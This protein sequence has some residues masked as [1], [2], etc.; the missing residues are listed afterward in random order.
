MAFLWNR[1]IG[2]FPCKQWSWRVVILGSLM[3]ALVEDLP[4]QLWLAFVG[5]MLE[6]L[7]RWGCQQPQ[8]RGSP[9]TLSTSQQDL[10]LNPPMRRFTWSKGSFWS[11]ATATFGTNHRYSEAPKAVMQTL[12]G[13]YILASDGEM[14]FRGKRVGAPTYLGLNIRPCACEN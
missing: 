5:D 10:K 13:W 1:D 9:A 8:W 3:L 11:L 6:H 12:S 14:L 7:P 2:G 4:S